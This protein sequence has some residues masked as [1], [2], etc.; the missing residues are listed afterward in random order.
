V[1]GGSE[2]VSRPRAPDGAAPPRLS[3][4]VPC[5]DEEQSLNALFERLS[6]ACHAV[7]GDDYE[8]VLV[9]DGSTDATWA[10]IAQLAERSERVVGV[11]LARNHGHQLALTAGLSVATGERVLI[12]DADLQ[13]PPELL[14]PMMALMDQGADVVYGQR[15]SRRGERWSKRASASLFYRLIGFLTDTDIPRDTGDFRLMSRRALDIFLAMPEQHRFVRG[16]VSWIGLRQVPLRYTRAERHAGETKYPFRRMVH[17]AFDAITGFSVRPLRIASYLGLLLAV[18]AM[19]VLAYTLGAWLS[20]GTVAGWTSVMAVVLI[21]GSAQ[22]VVLG[23]IGE[24]LG[25]LFVESKRRPL[26]I[27]DRLISAGRDVP[28]HPFGP[29]QVHGVAPGS[30]RS[31][32][33]GCA[34]VERQ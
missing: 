11:G 19:A 17:L 8:I 24:Y 27:I 23:V 34:G 20:G 32:E 29:S 16:M 28:V 13:D 15:E 26:F 3:A 6:E 5:Y 21:L 12:I 7:A 14:G 31:V 4:V 25:R 33:S 9:D 2:A 18:L 10:L 30:N 22:M 1:P